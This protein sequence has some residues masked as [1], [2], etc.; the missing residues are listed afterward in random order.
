MFNK[1]LVFGGLAISA[2]LIIE[3]MVTWLVAYVLWYNSAQAWTLSLVST[4]VWIAIWY[5]LKSMYVEKN[6]S[7]YDENEF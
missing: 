5:G 4:L 2:V 1:I 7:D 3:N 6:P